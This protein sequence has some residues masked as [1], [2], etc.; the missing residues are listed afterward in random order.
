MKKMLVV[1][2]PILT[3][4]GCTTPWGEIPKPKPIPIPVPTVVPTPTPTP[5][6][7][8]FP[9]GMQW[10]HV[11]ISKWPVTTDLK[12]TVNY[13]RHNESNWTCKV[14]L[15]YDKARVWPGVDNLSANPW[16]VC[17]HKGQWYAATW[18]WLRPGATLKDMDNKS[19]AGHIKRSQLS[20]F[21]PQPGA[22]YYFM[23]SGLC[24]DGRRNVQERSNLCKVVWPGAATVSEP[25]PFFVDPVTEEPPLVEV[26][27]DAPQ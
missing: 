25:W 20:D 11:D 16:I 7:S 13:R 15:S 27:E 8:E 23:V 14:Y 2:I 1:V 5:A 17:Q 18:E 9:P 26:L 21:E 6:V 22:T 10:L 3:L 24:R 12:A 19:W 4:A